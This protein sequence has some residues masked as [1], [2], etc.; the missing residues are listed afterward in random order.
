[1]HRV[2]DVDGEVVKVVLLL[3]APCVGDGV[4][5]DFGGAEGVALRQQRVCGR[6]GGGERRD[7]PVLTERR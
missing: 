3:L 1:M 4:Q 7:P 5:D 6:A 2:P